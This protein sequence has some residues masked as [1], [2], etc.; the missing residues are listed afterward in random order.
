YAMEPCIKSGDESCGLR[1]QGLWRLGACGAPR[2]VSRGSPLASYA[3]CEGLVFSFGLWARSVPE[4]PVRPALPICGCFIAHVGHIP[5]R[6]MPPVEFVHLLFDLIV[7][8]VALLGCELAVIG[9]AEL[10]EGTPILQSR[11]H[12]KAHQLVKALDH[13]RQCAQVGI[14]QG[15]Y[16]GRI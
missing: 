8:N 12:R 13:G 14:V 7:G 10:C 16:R 4:E 6:E 2:H 5:G 3:W 1:V 11:E 9:V 15:T